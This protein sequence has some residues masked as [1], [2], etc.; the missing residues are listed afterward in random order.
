MDEG[1]KIYMYFG[2]ELVAVKNWRDVPS[3]S[4]EVLVTPEG[5]SKP[6]PC[7]VKRVVWDFDPENSPFT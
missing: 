2:S 3:L 1:Y 4:D 6:I 5:A 7:K